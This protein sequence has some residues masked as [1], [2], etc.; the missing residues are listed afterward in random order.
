MQCE[1]ISRRRRT[2]DFGFGQNRA[3]DSAIVPICRQTR[4]PIRMSL[5]E[6]HTSTQSGS[7]T[8]NGVFGPLSHTVCFEPSKCK[9]SLWLQAKYVMLRMQDAVC[10]QYGPRQSV[11][12][13]CFLYSLARYRHVPSSIDVMQF[14]RYT[15]S[16]GVNTSYFSSFENLALQACE[17]IQL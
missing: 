3:T 16:R 5:G 2:L 7:V 11:T 15:T 4:A 8:P 9:Y 1:G 6:R 14:L 10:P 13:F 12:L 17:R